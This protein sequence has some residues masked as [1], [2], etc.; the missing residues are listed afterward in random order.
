METFDYDDIQLCLTSA[1]S[2]VAA[3]PIPALS[4]VPRLSSLPLFLPTWKA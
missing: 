4:L 2:R 1:S 3:K